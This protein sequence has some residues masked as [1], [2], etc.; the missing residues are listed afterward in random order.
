M[1]GRVNSKSVHLDRGNIN[2]LVYL[3][4]NSPA[5]Y[6]DILEYVITNYNKDTEETL[7]SSVGGD[8]LSL[9]MGHKR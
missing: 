3:S 5:N 8:Q 1:S 4:N 2:H 6:L 9:K 7:L